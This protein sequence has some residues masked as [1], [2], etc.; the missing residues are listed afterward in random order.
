MLPAFS[1]EEQANPTATI[2]APSSGFIFSPEARYRIQTVIRACESEI[3][4]TAR[5]F[6]FEPSQSALEAV[7]QA[8]LRL[9]ALRQILYRFS[10]D[11]E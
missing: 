2:T 1:R 8:Q 11:S 3:E 7:M 10:G 5:L 6:D 9:T 4:R